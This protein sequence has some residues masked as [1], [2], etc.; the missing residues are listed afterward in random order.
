VDFIEYFD[1]GLSQ[2]GYYWVHQ[3]ISGCTP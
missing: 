1:A 2:L 3:T